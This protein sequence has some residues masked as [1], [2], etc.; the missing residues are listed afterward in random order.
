MKVWCGMRGRNQHLVPLKWRG[1]LQA[2]AVGEKHRAIKPQGPSIFFFSFFNAQQSY[3]HTEFSQMWLTLLFKGLAPACSSPR[4]ALTCRRERETERVSESG[5]RLVV[6]L[7][8]LGQ[9][10]RFEAEA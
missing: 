3:G 8:G 5:V 1:V 2:D 9:P 10:Q 7:E 4:L 6:G